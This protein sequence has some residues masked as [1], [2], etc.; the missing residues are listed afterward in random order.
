M[1]QSP[2]QLA[3]LDTRKAHMSELA[4][5]QSAYFASPQ[6]ST[7]LIMPWHSYCW[8]S[9]AEAVMFAFKTGKV[10]K[11]SQAGQYWLC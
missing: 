6:L 8:L 7:Q 9:I 11:R 1:H 2:I 10:V 4:W 3:Y 5:R